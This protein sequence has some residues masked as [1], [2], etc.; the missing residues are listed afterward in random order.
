MQGAQRSPNV[1]SI[2]P[3]FLHVSVDVQ[4]GRCAERQLD[5]VEIGSWA[6][7]HDVS[8]GDGHAGDS[9]VDRKVAL[10]FAWSPAAVG[11]V[12]LRQIVLSAVVL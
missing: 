10:L 5:P 8:T 6:A 12:A 1:R 2:D 7:L 9:G 11:R 3:R 4:P